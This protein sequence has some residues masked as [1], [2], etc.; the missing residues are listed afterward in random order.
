MHIKRLKLKN[1]RNISDLSLEFGST[2][3]LLVGKNAQGKTN[4]VEAIGLISTSQSFRATDF[5]DM[6]MH[7]RESAEVCAQ[8]HG[9][10]GADTLVVKIGDRKKE[11]LKKLADYNLKNIF[12][13][14][15]LILPLECF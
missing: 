12:P 10:L 2:F 4:I 8:A 14:N 11:F 15:I 7:G 9:T 6:I 13:N 1:F 5:R 3:N